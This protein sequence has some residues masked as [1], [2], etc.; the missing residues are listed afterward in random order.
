M[1][2]RY[3]NKQ[4]SRRRRWAA[5][6]S[7]DELS[8]AGHP[9]ILKWEEEKLSRIRFCSNSG[10][11]GEKNEITNVSREL[12]AGSPQ[13]DDNVE[14][15]ITSTRN[16]SEE[17]KFF[18]L[19]TTRLE[20]RR[21]TFE[22]CGKILRNFPCRISIQR[23]LF[24]SFFLRNVFTAASRKAEE[25]RT[26]NIFWLLMFYREEGITISSIRMLN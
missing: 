5:E 3:G 24:R 8:F 4:S 12:F 19:D 26:F 16:M 14:E 1:R 7:A 21:E 20:C 15:I 17:I 2:A 11:E 25:W 13:L 9:A 23:E 18:R 22:R 6:N 10:D